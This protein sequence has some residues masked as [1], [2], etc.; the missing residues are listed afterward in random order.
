MIIIGSVRQTWLLLRLRT[1]FPPA[2]IVAESEEASFPEQQLRL[3]SAFPIPRLLASTTSLFLLGVYNRLADCYMRPVLSAPADVIRVRAYVAT[4][5]FCYARGTEVKDCINL[6]SY[7]YLG[8]SFDSRESEEDFVERRVKAVPEEER[9]DALISERS[10]Y[11]TGKACIDGAAGVLHTHGMATCCT[12]KEGGRT[13]ISRELERETAD[14]LH[15]EDAIVFGMGFATNSLSIGRLAGRGS[16]VVSD[17]LNHSSLVEGIRASGAYKRAFKHG[18]YDSLEKIIRAA[19]VEGQPDTGRPFTRIVIVVEGIYSMEGELVDLDIVVALKRKYKCHL[20]I[21]EAHSIGAL[22]PNGG[23]IVDFYADKGY[24]YD[25]VDVLMGTYTKSFGSVGGYIAGPAEAIRSIRLAGD[26]SLE[27]S[28]FSPPCAK[29]ALEALRC[30]RK[31]VSTK[32]GRQYG[33]IERL[34]KNSSY[35]RRK[36]IEMGLLVTGDDQSPVLPVMIFTPGRCCLACRIGLQRNVAMVIVGYPATPL[37]KCR[38]R[39]CVSAMLTKAQLDHA[40]ETMDYIAE[41]SC[42]RFGE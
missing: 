41:K 39:F 2:K 14:F 3:R 17:S 10:V 6:A 38:I 9:A 36:L 35:F 27:A 28:S 24:S 34:R 30:I 1:G 13:D 16:L 29:M 19:I 31:E 37:L 20:Y 33:R 7:N 4:T 12:N 22:G 15:K 25:D 26:G 42:C 8:F 11:R 5:P 21:D 40:L 18:D 32:E 23:G